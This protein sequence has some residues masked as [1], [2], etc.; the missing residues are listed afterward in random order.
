LSF[1][2]FSLF[3]WSGFSR[4]IV[5]LELSSS[6]SLLNVR[7]ALVCLIR[8]FLFNLSLLILP[9]AY[10]QSWCWRSWEFYIFIHRQQAEDLLVHI[11]NLKSTH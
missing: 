10:R 6:F 4:H 11:W 5:D 8:V 7:I 3:F 9:L 1:L 2:T